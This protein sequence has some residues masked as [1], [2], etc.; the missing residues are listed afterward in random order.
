MGGSSSQEQALPWS[1]TIKSCF[2]AGNTT[3]RKGKKEEGFVLLSKENDVPCVPWLMKGKEAPPSCK[4]ALECFE[5][6]FFFSSGNRE[7]L[8]P[9]VQN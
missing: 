2:L 8:V 3:G 7:P 6:V 1:Q 9:K 5:E 4:S